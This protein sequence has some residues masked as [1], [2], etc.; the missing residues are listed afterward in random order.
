MTITSLRKQRDHHSFSS[1][2]QYL[3]ICSLAYAF[4]YV[5]KLAAEFTP[6][7]LIFGSAFHAGAEWIAYNRSKGVETTPEQARDIFHD[8]FVVECESRARKRQ[9]PARFKK[10]EKEELAAKG[11]DMLATFAEKWDPT[12]TVVET[13]KTFCVPV[14]DRFDNHVELPLIGEFDCVVKDK[15]GNTIIIDWKTFARK[16]S[17]DKVRT[18]QQAT[19]YAYAMERMTGENPLFRYDVVTKTKTPAYQ[20]CPTRR[21]THDFHR[22]AELVKTVERGVKA[23]VF[24]PNETGY[25]CGN[26]QFKAACAAWGSE[27]SKLISTPA[28]AA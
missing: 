20:A 11:R 13:S 16:W 24:I 12:E 14:V 19:A 22:L 10:G 21:T 9:A 15:D 1:L 3:N 28:K 18:D 2:N 17:D 7:S 27:R 4:K 6:S 25:F 8:T 23:E 26:C 5:Y